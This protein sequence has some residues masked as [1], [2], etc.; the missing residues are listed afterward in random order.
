MTVD[1]RTLLAIA[2]AVVLMGALAWPAAQAL[3]PEVER[4]QKQIC[5]PLEPQPWTVRPARPFTLKDFAGRDISLDDYRGRVV[6]LNFWATW[7]PPCVDE[8]GALEKLAK[9]FKGRDDFV[10]LAVSEDQSWKDIRTFFP[11]GTALTV[12]MDQDWTV[13]HTWGTQ[14]LPDTYLVDK[15]GKV[16]HYFMNKRDWSSPQALACIQSLL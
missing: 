16:R 7:C 14:K 3:R 11:R 4:E 2:V 15:Q 12:L 1:Q 13:A 5:L 6:F 9:A 8:M 10:M